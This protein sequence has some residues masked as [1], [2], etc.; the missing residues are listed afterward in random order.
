MRKIKIFGN[1]FHFTGSDYIPGLVILNYFLLVGI[2][3]KHLPEFL[4]LHQEIK[5]HQT[6]VSDIYF[7]HYLNLVTIQISERYWFK[8]NKN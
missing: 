3:R 8:I 4:F 1:I 2:V 7:L 5:T 6:R